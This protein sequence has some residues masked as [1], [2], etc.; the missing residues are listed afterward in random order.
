MKKK[1]YAVAVGRTCG[2]FEDWPA[3]EAQVKGFAGAL[4]KGFAERSEAEAWLENPLHEKKRSMSSS[5]S[6]SAPTLPQ[7]ARPG[8]IVVHTDGGCL[9]NPGPGGY[10]VVI[11]IDG[12]LRE[13]S[14]G[15]RRT[16][17]NRMELLAVIVALETL[18]DC[19]R[20]VDLFSDSSYV[21]NAVNKGWAVR[22]EQGGWRRVD[23]G[24]VA[25]IDLWQRLL[26]LTDALD[27][28]LYWLKGH[29]GHAENERCDVLAGLAAKS[30]EL[31][32]DQGYGDSGDKSWGERDEQG[33]F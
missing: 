26:A 28:R 30:E 7:R 16:T 4:Y 24:D 6:S 15:F 25:N 1:C 31:S 29:A 18:R 14:G 33:I 3:A 9:S 8:A 11:D 27:L 17:N 23:G 19:G 22:W 2:I 5:A 13:L 10:G 32:V 12:E 20:P 21:V